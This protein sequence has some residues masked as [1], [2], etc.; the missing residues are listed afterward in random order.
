MFGNRKHEEALNGAW[1]E[2]GVIGTRIEIEGKN[3][4]ILWRNRPVLETTFRTAEED[5][6]IELI[7]K[8][9]DLRNDPSEKPYATVTRL[10]CKDGKLIFAEDFPISGPSTDVLSKTELSRYGNVTICDEVL[11]E[12][13]GNWVEANGGDYFHLTFQG[14]R[15]TLTGNGTREVHAVRSNGW[16]NE[17]PVMIIDADPSVYEWRGLCN[18]T[19][20]GGEIRLQ[21][22]VCDAPPMYITFRRMDGAPEPVVDVVPEKRETDA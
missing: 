18:M 19:Y 2:P 9:K 11:D 16:M 15:M 21:M 7:L 3:I 22:I 14:S 8:E 20:E 10:F 12:L 13:Q 17:P 4:T 5:G 6:G 1:Q